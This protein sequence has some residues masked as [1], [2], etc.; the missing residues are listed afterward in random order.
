IE[1]VRTDLLR[2]LGAPSDG[3]PLVEKGWLPRYAARRIA[4]H[5]LDHAWEIQDRS[6]PASA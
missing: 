3:E 1:A 6:G 5:V 4:W 2:V